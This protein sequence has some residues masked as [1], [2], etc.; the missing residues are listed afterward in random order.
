[1]G[2]ISALP[3][4]LIDSFNSSLEELFSSDYLLLVHDLSNP[5]IENEAKLVFDTL[6]K[7]GFTEEVLKSKVINIFNK[8]DINSNVDNIDIKFKNKFVKTCAL[9]KDGTKNLINYLEKLVDKNFSDILFFIPTN[10]LKISSWLHKNS[11]VY[12][13]IFCN[14]NFTGN[15]VKSKISNQKLEHFKSNFPH[16]K[17]NSIIQTNHD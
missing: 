3:T 11:F 6:K 10:S 15:K 8:S 9:T 4:E 14:T 2:F 16:I 12:N 13:D 1:M 5:N 17:I 7:I